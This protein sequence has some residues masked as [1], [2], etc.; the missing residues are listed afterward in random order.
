MNQ[1]VNSMQTPRG[2]I[3]VNQTSEVKCDQCG[4]N[5]F[6]QG[7]FLRKISALVSPEGRDG[8]LPIPTFHCTSCGAVNDEFVPAE[9][10]N[11]IKLV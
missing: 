4:N 7:V 10:K 6:S 8:Y 1:P 3:D 2:G 9:L 5:V 11:K